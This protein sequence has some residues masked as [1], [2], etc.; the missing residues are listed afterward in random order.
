MHWE[1]SSRQRFHES[2]NRKKPHRSQ[3]KISKRH[4]PNCAKKASLSIVP[5]YCEWDTEWMM[6]CEENTFDDLTNHEPIEI[7][8][9][10][11]SDLVISK[12]SQKRTDRRRIKSTVSF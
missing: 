8:S 2:I 4:Q 7:A 11:L 3:Q 9:V 6:D 1:K 5:R 12:P 10:K